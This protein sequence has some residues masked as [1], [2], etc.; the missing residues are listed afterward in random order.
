MRTVPVTTAQ[1]FFITHGL[2]N[3]KK[4]NVWETLFTKNQIVC[5]GSICFDYRRSYDFSPMAAQPN[6]QVCW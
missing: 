4:L 3:P 2:K 1:Y 6:A 5:I